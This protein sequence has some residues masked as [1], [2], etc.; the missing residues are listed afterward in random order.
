MILSFIISALWQG[1]L[2]AGVTVLTLHFVPVRNAATRY[3]A[4]FVTALSLAAVPLLSTTVHWHLPIF[5]ALEHGAPFGRP[6]FSLLPFGPLEQNASRLALPSI[7]GAPSIVW[8]ITA[9]WIAGTALAL[10][11]LSVSYSRIARLRHGAQLVS[12]VDRVPVL[13]SSDLS[14]PIAAGIL[15]PA[16]SIPVELLEALSPADLQ[17]TIEHELAHVRRG[18]VTTNALERLLEAAFFWNPWIYFV[19]RRLAAEREAA[20]DDWAVGRLGEPHAYANCLAQLG[21]RI[22]EPATP[23]LTPSALGSRHSLVTRIERLMAD[24][25]PTDAKLNYAAVGGITMLFVAMTVALQSL[26]PVPV[27]ANALTTNGAATVAV[28]CKDPNAEPQA[29]NPA[30]PHLP[31]SEWPTHKVS[32]IVAVKVGANGKAAGARVYHSSGNANL[33]RA[34]L[35]AAEESTYTP[36]LVN[37]VPED[38]VYLFTAE[39]GPGP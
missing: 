10:A 39:F 4:W 14:M 36:R 1:A 27:R 12:Q 3:A 13:A 20:C 22:H 9:F 25:S 8:S 29:L 24:R 15:A 28:S 38:G 2:I 37:C 7:L 11:R 19:G 17:C 16:I 33:D 31:K 5:A 6:A 30:E 35:K 26:A 21:R 18:D 23:L 34:V 32:A